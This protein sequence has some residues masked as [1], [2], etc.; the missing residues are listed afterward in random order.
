M[1]AS[2]CNDSCQDE[3]AQLGF[4][5]ARKAVGNMGR[6]RGGQLRAEKVVPG[7]ERVALSQSPS[8][9]LRLSC[10]WA[11]RADKGACWAAGEG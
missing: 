3:L 2:G 7:T 10:I 11:T 5:P 8:C 1:R 4:V 6:G 9:P